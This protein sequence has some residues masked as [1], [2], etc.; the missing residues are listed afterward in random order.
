MTTTAPVEIVYT[1]ADCP[2]YLRKRRGKGFFYTDETGKKITDPAILKQIQSLVIPPN[3][4]YVWICALPNG[5]IQA[6]GRDEKGRKQYIYHTEYR[7][8]RQLEKFGRIVEFAHLLPIIR[9]TT[10]RHLNQRHW[11]KQ[12]MLALVVQ[13]L[14]ECPMRIGNAYYRDTNNTFGLTTLRRRHLGFNKDSVTFS[15]VGKSH[16]SHVKQLHNKRLARLI[17]QSS[18]LPGHEIFRYYNEDGSMQTITSQDVNAYLYEITGA[19]M[20]SKNFRT[21]GGTSLA[22]YYYPIVQEELAESK[23]RGKV[24][25]QVVKKVAHSLGN[26]T[27]VCREYYIHPTV[28]KAITNETLPSWKD[29]NNIPKNIAPAEVQ[30]ALKDYELVTLGVL[31]EGGGEL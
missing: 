20:S 17:K 11:T 22:V 14:D 31:V 8:S 13:I 30:A 23:S 26:T 3:W 18:E 7:K 10:D 29:P 2:G 28:L 21:W 5:H 19:H 12:K 24:V 4:E 27:T 15:F 25:N 16:Q 9:A 6:H 1:A